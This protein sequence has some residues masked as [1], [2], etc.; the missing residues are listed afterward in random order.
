MGPPWNGMDGPLLPLPHTWPGGST[1]TLSVEGRT[2]HSPETLG[3]TADRT[4]LRDGNPEVGTS[5]GCG[6]GGSCCV[7]LGA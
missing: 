1:A 7:D 4:Y 6:L 5:L 2:G 3:G